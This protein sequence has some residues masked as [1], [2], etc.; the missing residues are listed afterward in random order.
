MLRE[1]GFA[2]PMRGFPRWAAM[3]SPDEFEE[4]GWKIS[5]AERDSAGLPK[6]IRA[7]RPE[8]LDAPAIRL[9]V[10]IENRMRHAS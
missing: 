7:S 2:M 5:V 6:L 1:L 3:R 4:E 8:S 9:T 10:F